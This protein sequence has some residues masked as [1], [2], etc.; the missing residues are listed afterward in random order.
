MGDS[1]DEEYD[2]LCKEYESIPTIEQRF[3]TLKAEMSK[4]FQQF[5][6]QQNELLNPVWKK[7]DELKIKQAIME[8]QVIAI[9]ES[10]DELSNSLAILKLQFNEEHSAQEA[11]AEKIDD[12][13][14][15]TCVISQ[16]VAALKLN[17]AEELK[18]RKAHAEKLEALDKTMG[19]I[20]QQVMELGQTSVDN[21]TRCQILFDQQNSMHTN[22]RRLSQP[23]KAHY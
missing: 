23:W 1:V 5:Q 21:N 14:K 18:A 16:Q 17:V 12:L 7:L 22:I 8:D 10:Q 11:R 19:T 13:G 9:A 4:K 6:Q 2:M 3:E 15:T 20:A